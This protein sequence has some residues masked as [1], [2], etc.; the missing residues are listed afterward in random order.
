VSRLVMVTL[1]PAMT[2]WL[3]L[4]SRKD[5]LLDQSPYGFAIRAI[6]RPPVPTSA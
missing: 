5:L 3:D 1:G 6:A 2:A 4:C